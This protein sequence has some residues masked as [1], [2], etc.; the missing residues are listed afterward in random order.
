MPAQTLR[1]S[2]PRRAVLGTVL[3]GA[4]ALAAVPASAAYVQVID[5]TGTTG[6]VVVGVANGDRVVEG[7]VCN[8]SNYSGGYYH[9]AAPDGT[10]GH[11]QGCGG[12]APLI[13]KPSYNGS[14]LRASVDPNGLPTTVVVEVTRFSDGEKRSAEL[15]IGDGLGPVQ[16]ELPVAFEAGSGRLTWVLRATNTTE[17]AGPVSNGGST[18]ATGNH[19]S[20]PPA[21]PEAEPSAGA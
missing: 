14:V 5:P 10:V 11:K 18:R 3:A 16:V 13:S 2:A 7:G 9:V 1:S 4:L 19:I 17:V 6:G 12:D 8:R 15:E 21:E 20:Q